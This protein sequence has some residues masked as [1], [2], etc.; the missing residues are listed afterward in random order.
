MNTA[1]VRNSRSMISMVWTAALAVLAVACGDDAPSED[2]GTGI[3]LPTGGETLDG[4]TL[5]EGSGTADGTE[6]EG[7]ELPGNCGASSFMR[8]G[9]G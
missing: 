6:S 1:D 3:Q 5:D 8:P 9:H 4:G 2:G 7:D